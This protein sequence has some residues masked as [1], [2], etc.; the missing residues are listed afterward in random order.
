M[1]DENIKVFDLG[2]RTTN[3]GVEIILFCK[4]IQQNS[5]SRPIIS[6]LVRSGTSIGANYSEANEFVTK[7]DFQYKISIAKKEAKETLY[8]LKMVDCFEEN[9][10]KISNLAKEVQE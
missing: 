3:F 1:K 10:I 4:Q 8:W 9:K 5:V 6:Q 7:K 2:K